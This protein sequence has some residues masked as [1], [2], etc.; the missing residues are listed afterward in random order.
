MWMTSRPGGFDEKSEVAEVEKNRTRSHYLPRL[1]V[2][3]G[4]GTHVE[5]HVDTS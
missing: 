1:L 4:Y 5:A 3:G 2:A